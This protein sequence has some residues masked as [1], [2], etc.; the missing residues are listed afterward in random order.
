MCGRHD[1]S[2]MGITCESTK[3]RMISIDSTLVR[4]WAVL[5]Q[6]RIS[7]ERRLEYRKDKHLLTVAS[8][9]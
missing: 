9:L 2:G 8:R 7:G 1:T 5:Y 4:A 6:H 3:E